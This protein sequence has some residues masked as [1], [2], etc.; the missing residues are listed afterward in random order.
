LEAVFNST[1][2]M[3]LMVVTGGMVSAGIIHLKNLSKDED[4]DHTK[5]SI[6]HEWDELTEAIHNSRIREQLE[7]K[8]REFLHAS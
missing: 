3:I 2:E 7:A 1:E 4:Y 8:C 5:N 6:S